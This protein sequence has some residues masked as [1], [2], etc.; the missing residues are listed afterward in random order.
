MND[1]A[2][3]GHDNNLSHDVQYV[4][5]LLSGTSPSQNVA[6]RQPQHK[7]RRQQSHPQQAAGHSTQS[8][9]HPLIA[10][11]S[12]PSSRSR[13]K[14]YF[15]EACSCWLAANEQLWQ[16]HVAGARHQ[17]QLVSLQHTG[18]LGNTVV[19]VFEAIPGTSKSSTAAGLSALAV[20]QSTSQLTCRF[21][22]EEAGC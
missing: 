21:Q 18:Q 20:P 3:A 8:E 2:G 1:Q 14:Q 9:P 15:C 22:G 6:S 11:H 5:S 17:R 12:R 19:S 16:A 10:L 7:R 4:A 13:P